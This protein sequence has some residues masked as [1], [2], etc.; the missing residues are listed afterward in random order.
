MALQF[1]SKG[2]R[3]SKWVVLSWSIVA[4]LGVRMLGVMGRN[5]TSSGGARVGG[6]APTV[7]APQRQTGEQRDSRLVGR[8]RHTHT[9]VSGDFTA[10]TDSFLVLKADGTA[11]AWS[12]S[13]AAGA[14]HSSV[15]SHGGAD[16]ERGRWKTENKT[17]YVTGG[18]GSWEKLGTYAADGERFMVNKVVW[19]KL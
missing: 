19:E 12:G 10:A 17:L 6:D 5:A 7:V 18:D 8:W 4:I 3:P 14:S 13:A 1:G 2:K 16:V 9:Y 11:E 15:V